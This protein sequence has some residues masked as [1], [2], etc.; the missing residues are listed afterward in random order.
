MR[1]KLSKEQVLCAA[2]GEPQ[3]PHGPATSARISNLT[4]KFPEVAQVEQPLETS[5]NLET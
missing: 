3:P 1:T 4:K 5:K 2:R